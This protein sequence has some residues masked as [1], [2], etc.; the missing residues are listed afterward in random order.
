MKERLLGNRSW[1]KKVVNERENVRRS[2][3]NETKK[4]EEGIEEEE[5]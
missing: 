5:T 4:D 3:P 1:S 2:C